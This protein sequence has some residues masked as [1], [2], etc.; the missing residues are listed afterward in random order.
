MTSTGT[1]DGY[2]WQENEGDMA[3]LLAANP[4]VVKGRYLAI[5]ATDSPFPFALPNGW[6]AT[7]GILYTPRI[8][9]IEALRPALFS[10]G[11]CD[12]Q[13][14]FPEAYVFDAP[15]ALSPLCEDNVFVAGVGPKHVFRLSAT[16][17]M[18]DVTDLLWAQIAW[19]RP[20]AYIAAG[21]GRAYFITRNEGPA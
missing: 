6:R 1:R 11:C 15:P 14:R 20:R 4:D 12:G 17:A 5:T 3:A 13:Y 2:T 18:K 16:D 21:E 19:M 7:G 10:G 9:G 8:E